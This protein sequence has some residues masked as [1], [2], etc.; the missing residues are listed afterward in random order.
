MVKD[1]KESKRHLLILAV[2]CGIVGMV[3]SALVLLLV[4]ALMVNGI[5]P[6]S[7]MDELVICSVVIGSAAGGTIC[8]KKRGGGVITAGLAAAGVYLTIILIGTIFTAKSVEEGTLTLKIIVAA[9]AGGCFGGAL[10]LYRRTKKSK[11]RK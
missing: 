10:R 1:K 9:L 5:L 2:K 4:A 3:V 6:Q 7:L 8:A 11:Y